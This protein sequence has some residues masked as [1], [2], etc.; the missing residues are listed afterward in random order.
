MQILKLRPELVVTDSDYY[1][2]PDDSEPSSAELQESLAELE[3]IT[4]G[5]AA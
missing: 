5:I 3:A 1:P 4:R 2:L